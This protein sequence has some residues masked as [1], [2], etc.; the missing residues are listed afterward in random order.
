MGGGRQEEIRTS[1]DSNSNSKN[2]KIQPGISSKG[3]VERCHLT[4]PTCESIPK[5]NRTSLHK[6]LDMNIHTNNIYNSQNMET[7]QVSIDEWISKMWFTHTGN[8]L[9]QQG[10]KFYAWSIWANLENAVSQCSI[11]QR[12][13]EEGN[14]WFVCSVFDLFCFDRN[15]PRSPACPETSF[16]DQAGLGLRDPTVSASEH[17]D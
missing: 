15:S 17:W 14:S 4:Q 11:V 10:I 12:H 3:W 13:H 5:E 9:W 7:T 6:I 2:K 16:V 8:F 1:S